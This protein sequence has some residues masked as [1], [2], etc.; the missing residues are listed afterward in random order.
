M[1]FIHDKLL[2][3]RDTEVVAI[4]SNDNKK[5]LYMDLALIEKLLS[6]GKNDIAF[7]ISKK[8]LIGDKPV[9]AK[10]MDLASA[11]LTNFDKNWIKA[12]AAFLLLIPE[13]YVPTLES[14]DDKLTF[15]CMA[16][17]T[18]VSSIDVEYYVRSPQNSRPDLTSTFHLLKH[19]K[20]RASQLYGTWFTGIV[21]VPITDVKYVT[22][23]GESVSNTVSVT[24]SEP[25]SKSIK[26][27]GGIA[28]MIQEPQESA[29]TISADDYAALMAEL[30][31]LDDAY[32]AKQVEWTKDKNGTEQVRVDPEMKRRNDATNAI[33]D[34]LA[35][36]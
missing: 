8:H 6:Y 4:A 31:A 23:S 24:E 17:D 14:E 36:V 32:E 11:I 16:L 19:Y 29:D 18:I 10:S 7:D 2:T 28:D 25:S 30:K 5:Y 13:E 9:S 21:V 22:E 33:N 3:P 20:S 26:M 27:S 1:I 35:R 12:V 34:L 15:A